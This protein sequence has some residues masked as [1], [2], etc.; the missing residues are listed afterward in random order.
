MKTL[1]SSI[2]WHDAKTDLIDDE[3]SVLVCTEDDQVWIGHHE[4]GLWFWA[5]GN[6][7]TSPVRLWAEIPAPPQK[8]KSAPVHSPAVH[9]LAVS[10]LAGQFALRT[11]APAWDDRLAHAWVRL[12]HYLGAHPGL[13][14][15]VLIAVVLCSATAA[16]A[17]TLRL[18]RPGGP[19]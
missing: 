9:S 10:M 11:T 7:I 17:C 1:T 14:V 6:E 2:T 8:L 16:V 18:L 3:T 13:A 15:L 12:C 4:D 19:R 5:E